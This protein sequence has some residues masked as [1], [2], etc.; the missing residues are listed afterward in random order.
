MCVALFNRQRTSA[1][2]R[3][4]LLLRSSRCL[5]EFSRRRNETRR[6]RNLGKSPKHENETGRRKQM[7]IYDRTEKNGQTN[8]VTEK[9][10]RMMR[11]KERARDQYKKKLVSRV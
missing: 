6:N 10:E 5:I 7:K 11:E 3:F 9:K 1:G 2:Y 8:V 4:R